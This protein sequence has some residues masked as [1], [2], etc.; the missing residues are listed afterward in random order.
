MTPKLFIQAITKLLAGIILVGLL[1]FFPAG[2]PFFGGILLM[3]VLFVPITCVG[4]VM[5]IKNPDLLKRRLDAKE[6]L[7]EQKRVVRL[8]GI[9]FL[10]GFVISGLTVRF[11]WYT[12]PVGVS[13]T[14]AVVFLL[15]YVIYAEVLR[16]NTYLSRTV[17]VTSGQRVIDTGLYGIVRHPMYFATVIMFI[18]MPF[19]LGSIYAAPIF[20]L[21]PFIIAKRI[22]SE[23]E[24]LVRELEGYVEYKEKVKYRL[25]PLVW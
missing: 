19:I 9:M 12:L 15:G 14:A 6:K 16:E 10:S 22:I 18:S 21:Y 13:Y 8:C 11:G 5:M 3:A 24:L 17:E 25:I 7:A 1:I 20:M 4:I 2:G 23:E